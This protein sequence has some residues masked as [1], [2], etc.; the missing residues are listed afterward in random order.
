VRRA[1]A[2][3]VG[4]VN[5]LAMRINQP[6]RLHRVFNLSGA[7]EICRQLPDGNTVWP[8]DKETSPCAE[9]LT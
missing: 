8:L 2:D 3:R 9:P 5:Q 6:L 7:N 1:R 4:A